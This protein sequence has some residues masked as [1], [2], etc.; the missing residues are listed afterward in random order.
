LFLLHITIILIFL[1]PAWTTTWGE[2]HRKMLMTSKSTF[3][4]HILC[5]CYV[6]R[7]GCTSHALP[8][9][10]HAPPQIPTYSCPIQPG[11]PHIANTTPSR[12]T[13]APEPHAPSE[14]AERALST[15]EKSPAPE[16]VTTSKNSTTKQAQQ[17]AA[18]TPAAPEPVAAPVSPQVR[19]FAP[20]PQTSSS[21]SGG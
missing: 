21:R 2:R 3:F 8:S 1:E 18:P 7:A 13:Q 10:P 5:S 11:T 20:R 19:L 4:F 14:F 12:P 9:V 15:A 6:R 16:T 17:G